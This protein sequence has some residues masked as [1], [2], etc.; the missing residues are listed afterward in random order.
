MG[1]PGT[2]WR[3]RAKFRGFDGRARVIQRS[4]ST[5]KAARQALDDAL[6]EAASQGQNALTSQDTFDTA[7]T[8]W[9]DDLAELVAMGERSPSTL[10][11]YRH[12]WTKH[13][14]P[15]LGR[16]RLAQVTVPVVDRFVVGLH[17]KVGPATARTARAIVSGAM[18]RAVREGAVPANPAREVRRLSARPKHAPRALTD[19]ERAR[20]FLT[21][22]NDEAAVRHE[23]PQLSAFMLATGVRIGEALALVWREVDLDAG[24]A[25]ITSTIIRVKGRGLVRKPTKTQAGDRPLV[26]PVWCVRMLGE[27]AAVGVGPDEPVFGTIDGTFRDPRN[28]TRWFAAARREAGLEWMT[29]HSWRKTTASVL[30]GSGLSA[31]LIADQLGHSR[32]S[33]TQDVYLGRRLADP[34]V[35]QALEM[36][37]PRLGRGREKSDER[38][39]LTITGEV[40]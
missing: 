34:R 38:N 10:D 35:V 27:R 19:E 18:G 40:L 14:S 1:E 32:V 16:L 4:A 7:V 30:D 31:R 39:G 36:V 23:L 5:R 29:S 33:M 12:T 22:A 15:A 20:W 17:R 24:T 25:H 11:H 13:V 2:L 6:R 28:V 37:D 8:T 3:C 26:L 21:L 9:L